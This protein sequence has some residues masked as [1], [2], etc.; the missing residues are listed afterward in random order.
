LNITL[1]SLEYPGL[2]GRGGGN[3]LKVGANNRPEIESW[4]QVRVKKDVNIGYIIS[5]YLSPQPVKVAPGHVRGTGSQWLG[6]A[7]QM[8]FDGKL[9]YLA[10]HKIIRLHKS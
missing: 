9:G 3:F 7:G 8:Y 2:Q 10:P 6:F 4:T 5:R 1:R